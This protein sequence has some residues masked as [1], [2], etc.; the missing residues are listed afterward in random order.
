MKPSSQ[1]LEFLSDHPLPWL[2]YDLEKQKLIMV[3]DN[4]LMSTYRMCPQHFIFANVHGYAQK[5]KTRVD[6]VERVWYLDFGIILHKMLEIYYRDFR[7]PEFNLQDWSINRAT[8]EWQEMKMDVHAEHKEYK[9]IGGLPG[10]IGL[11]FQ[12]GMTFTPQ[13]E[14]LRIIAQEVS[15]G[16]RMEVPLCYGL[17]EDREFYLAGRMD[18]VVDDGYFISPMDHK[19]KGYFKG[20][21]ALEYETDEGPTGYIYALS[22][23][24]PTVIPED[25]IL[26]RNCNRILMNL[27]SKK[28]MDSPAERFKRVPIRKTDGQLEEYRQRMISTCQ[29]MLNDLEEYV[30]GWA[31]KRNTSACTNWR[32][33]PCKFQD[34]CRQQGKDAELSTL[35][36]GFVQIKLWDTEEVLPTT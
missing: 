33:F 12:F 8:A 10:F 27:I 25:Q 28:T 30:A 1:L 26:K 23:I 2:K 9:S 31:V 35:K 13:N 20:D 29:T 5:S 22:K 15:F 7:K 18:L 4:H 16:K 24:L 3:V 34:I 14:K 36:N 17:F 21:P 11:L 32:M 6:D 19:S